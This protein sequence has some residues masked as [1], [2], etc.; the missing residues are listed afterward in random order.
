MAM[1]PGVAGAAT[2]TWTNELVPA[3]M[4]VD[5]ELTAVSC[6]TATD[7]VAVPAHVDDAA[8]FVGQWNGSTWSTVTIP[9]LPVND[10]I[11][12]GV[13]CAS[14]DACAVVGSFFAAHGL[15]ALSAWWNGSTWTAEPLRVPYQ[16]VPYGV[17]CSSATNCLA[18]GAGMVGPGGED[19]AMVQHWNGRTW[20]VEHPVMP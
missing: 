9:G 6:P 2:T 4:A 5:G 20:T 16:W 19:P 7:C 12:R 1:L 8:P 15:P 14:A 17:S 3:P 11:W 10:Y 13:S 18:V